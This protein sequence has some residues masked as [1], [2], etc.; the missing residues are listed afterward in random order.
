MAIW[1]ITASPLIMGN[2]ARQVANASAAILLNR[3]AI[4]IDQDGLGV[5]GERLTA[6][7]QQVW[8]RP[9]GCAE[10]GCPKAVALYNAGGKAP[11]PIPTGPCDDWTH[12]RGAYYDASGGAAGNL[13]TFSELS[14]AEA[15][16]ACCENPHCAGF[17]ISKGA[18]KGSGYYKRNAQGG[19]TTAEG[20]DGYTKPSQVPT[21]GGEAADVAVKLEALGFEAA[22]NVT[23]VWSGRFLGTFS[24]EYRAAAVGFHDTAFVR[25]VAA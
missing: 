3:R 25:M 1:A 11:P 12:T 21:G 23:D 10:P 15:Q 24:R 22:V 7:A 6:G 17:S 8:A 13:G 2:D 9:L 4:A 19:L 18:S 14:V 5:G 16:A 20:Y